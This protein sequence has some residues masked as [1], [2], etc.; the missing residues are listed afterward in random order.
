MT[1]I[2]IGV[3]NPLIFDGRQEAAWEKLATK[4]K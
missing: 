4:N 3:P 2:L 1:P